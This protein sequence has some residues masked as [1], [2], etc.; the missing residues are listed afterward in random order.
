V[1]GKD[2]MEAFR[3]GCENYAEVLGN[4]LEKIELDSACDRRPGESGWLNFDICGPA[5]FPCTCTF[6]LFADA[7]GRRRRQPFTFGP[8]SVSRQ[9]PPGAL[10]GS[11]S[12]A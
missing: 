4:F 6:M 7:S 10:L 2:I 12:M 3:L 5:A 11:V 9:R 8:H 1:G